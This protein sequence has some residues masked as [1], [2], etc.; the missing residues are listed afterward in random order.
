MP[1]SRVLAASLLAFVVG[2]AGAAGCSLVTS[3]DGLTGGSDDAAAATDGAASDGATSGGDAIGAGDAGGSGDGAGVGD[4]GSDAAS[5]LCPG[6]DGP[7]PVRVGSFCIDSTVVTKQQYLKFLGATPTGVQPAF[8]SWN[9]T[10]VPSAEWPPT[11]TDGNYPVV[12]VD[13]CDALAYCTWAGKRLC[14]AIGGG[15]VPATGTADASID[16][17]YAACS[18]GG[19]GQHAYPYGNTYEPAVCNVPEHDAGL[20]PVGSQTCV[21]GYPGLSD[22]TGNVYEWED[23]CSAASG[24]TDRCSARS[25]SFQDPSGVQQT[26]GFTSLTAR[27]FADHDVGFRCCSSP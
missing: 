15:S 2:S 17:W 26:C 24:A 22:M 11:T 23:S 8:C 20:Q 18:H 9:A 1:T 3:L 7:T 16:Q 21:G 6:G 19:D 12:Y 14:G 4:S 5:L 25:G 13:W 10:F 27:D